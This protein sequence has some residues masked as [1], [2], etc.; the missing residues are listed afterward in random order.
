MLKTIELKRIT[1]ILLIFLYLIPAIGVS[2]NIHK[3]GK[4]WS[5]TFLNSVSKK[6]CKCGRKTTHNCCKDFN[7]SF[8]ITENQ[9]DS[10]LFSVPGNSFEKVL[11]STYPSVDLLVPNS[12]VLIYTANYSPPPIYKRPV[13]LF[14]RTFLI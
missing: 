1:L 14:H 9:K 13:Y 5:F 8:K 7:L 3:C 6:K 4:T 12:K 11:N 10:K 2:V